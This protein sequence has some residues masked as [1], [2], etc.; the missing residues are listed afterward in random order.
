MNKNIYLGPKQHIW[1][2]CWAVTKNFTKS[3]PASRH[4]SGPSRPYHHVLHLSFFLLS[5]SAALTVHSVHSVNISTPHY[6]SWLPRFPPLFSV[7]IRTP[8]L[9]LCSP[10]LSVL[11]FSP[12]FSVS[13]RTPFLSIPS[14]FL[15]VQSADSCQL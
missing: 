8:F 13:V 1:T 14:L 2:C 15:A 4:H 6:H 3:I 11:R 9:S 5:P 7:S 10:F 12:L